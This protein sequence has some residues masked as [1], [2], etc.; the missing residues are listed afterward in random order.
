MFCRWCQDSF[1][2]FPINLFDAL[3]LDVERVLFRNCGDDLLG[4]LDCPQRNVDPHIFKHVGH[5][6]E[7]RVDA[8]QA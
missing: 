6:A 1:A 3:I 5:L 8:F 7:K 2:A 4:A